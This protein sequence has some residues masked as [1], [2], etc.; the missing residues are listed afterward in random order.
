[1]KMAVTVTGFNQQY[2]VK[3]LTLESESCRIKPPILQMKNGAV[4]GRTVSLDEKMT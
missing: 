3:P 2:R 1:M 4:A